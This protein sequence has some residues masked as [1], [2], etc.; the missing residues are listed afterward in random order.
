[1]AST[2][3]RKGLKQIGVAGDGSSRTYCDNFKM[4]KSQGLDSIHLRLFK[5][6]RCGIADQKMY[7]KM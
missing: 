4:N 6:L 3:E 1:M 2:Q 5:E 7:Q